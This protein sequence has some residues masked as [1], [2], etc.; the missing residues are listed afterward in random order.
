MKDEESLPLMSK[1]EVADKILDRVVELL[2]KK[3]GG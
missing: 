2:T 3:A 1:R